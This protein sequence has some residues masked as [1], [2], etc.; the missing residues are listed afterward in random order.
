MQENGLRAHG[1]VRIRRVVAGKPAVLIPNL[2]QRQFTV[3]QPDKAWV[4]DI[5][6]IRTWEGWLYLA[7]VIDLLS[8]KVVGAYSGLNLPTIPFQTEPRVLIQ[9]APADPIWVRSRIL[10]G[11]QHVES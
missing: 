6:Y 4:T 8:R 2:L 10:V 3:S 9:C 5:T 1:G 11:V 7:V